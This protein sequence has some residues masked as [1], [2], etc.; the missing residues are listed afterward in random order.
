MATPTSA[1]FKINLKKLIKTQFADT[2][3]LKC[4]ALPEDFWVN[5]ISASFV[6]TVSWWLHHGMKEA[7]EQLAV[8]FNHIL[9]PLI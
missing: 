7:P 9:S 2:G 5:H 4:S 6:E 8:Y 3:K 1:D